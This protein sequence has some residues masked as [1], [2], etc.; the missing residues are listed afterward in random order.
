MKP[1]GSFQQR[2]GTQLAKWP[3]TKLAVSVHTFSEIFLHACGA[4]LTFGTV[5]KPKELLEEI[6]KLK[7]K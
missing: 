5:K 1:A 3:A 4:S 2:T 7:L 6:L